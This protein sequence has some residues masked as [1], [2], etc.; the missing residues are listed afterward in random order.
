VSLRGSFQLADPSGPFT[1]GD[2]P[3]RVRGGTEQHSSRTE[4]Y[5]QSE[6]HQAW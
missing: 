5:R 6:E 1:R 4:H 3:R 2:G